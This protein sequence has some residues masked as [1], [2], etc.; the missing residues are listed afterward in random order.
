MKKYNKTFN[1]KQDC[2]LSVFQCD[3]ITH[4]HIYVHHLLG[5]HSSI[6]T[7]THHQLCPVTVKKSQGF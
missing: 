7:N 5:S 4:K 1:N 2:I 3:I 6:S